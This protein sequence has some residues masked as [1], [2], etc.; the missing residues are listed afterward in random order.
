[1]TA[2]LILTDELLIGVGSNRRCYVHPQNNSR[3]VKVL[4]GEDGDRDWSCELRYR[5]RFGW[6][7]GREI[8]PIYYGPVK[9]NF[10]DGQ[11][12]DLIADTDGL[13]SQGLEHYLSPAQTLVENFT[14]L[15][16]EFCV[17]RE[18]LLSGRVITR[19][20][21][22]CNLLRQEIAPRQFRL[23][24]IDDIGCGSLLPI[25][26][27]FRFVAR[28]RAAKKWADFLARLREQYPFSLMTE[29]CEKIK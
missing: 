7:A 12:F 17:F 21:N 22:L 1:M 23:R 29:L 15:V 18:F 5:R 26:D 25:A 28:R 8:I 11:V 6:D 27:Y 4:Y 2:P 10:G 16:E 14:A 13:A 3:C 19:S 9:T 24:L 20:I